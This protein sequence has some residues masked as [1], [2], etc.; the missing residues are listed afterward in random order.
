MG[1]VLGESSG[2]NTKAEVQGRVLLKRGKWN[3]T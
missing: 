2:K 3:E 1:E